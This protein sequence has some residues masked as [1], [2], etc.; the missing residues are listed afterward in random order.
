MY[1]ISFS[2]NILKNNHLKHNIPSNKVGIQRYLRIVHHKIKHH[3]P[4]QKNAISSS[5][6]NINQFFNFLI[7]FIHSTKKKLTHTS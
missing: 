5:A 6:K 2:F 7:L 1:N 4:T 3:P